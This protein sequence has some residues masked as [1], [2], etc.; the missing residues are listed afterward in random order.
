LNVQQR[1]SSDHGKPFEDIEDIGEMRRIATYFRD[2]ARTNGA[3]LLIAEA[4]ASR[5]RQLLEQKTRGFSLLSRMS[6]DF[7]ATAEPS[8]LTKVLAGHLNS[9]LNMKR[10]IVLMR[11]TSQ[12][13]FR[14]LASAGYSDAEQTRLQTLDFQLPRHI[15]DARR[16]VSTLSP[17]AEADRQ[18]FAPL[19]IPYF[20]AIPITADEEVKALIVTGR[21]R[22]QRPFSPPLNVSDM[23]TLR[24]IGGFFGAYLARYALIERDREQSRDRIAEV[25]RLVALRTAE[26]E[27]QRGLLDASLRD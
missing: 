6:S 23:D 25:E 10:T 22:E 2:M 9:I 17:L 13:G 15:D 19:D 8:Y 3:R 21:M 16:I 20:I 11:D 26:I 12:S 24:A 5:N 7:L 18:A 4:N 1:Q 14:I 27:R